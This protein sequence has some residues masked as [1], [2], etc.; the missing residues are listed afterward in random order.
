MSEEIQKLKDRIMYFESRILDLNKELDLA[1]EEIQ[2]LNLATE[3]C[4]KKRSLEISFS[5]NRINELL[6]ISEEHQKVNGKLREKLSKYE[7]KA[8]HYRRKGVI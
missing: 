8:A 6:K 2:A 4:E 7:D 5:V 3:K 1:K